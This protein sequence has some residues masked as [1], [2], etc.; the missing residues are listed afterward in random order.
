M[1][2]KEWF[3]RGRRLD[4]RIESLQQQRREEWERATS[5]TG[6]LDGDVVDGTK[7]PHKFDRFAVLDGM[8]GEEIDELLLIKCEIKAVIAQLDD[9]RYR[10]VLDKRY[11]SGKTWEQIAVEMNYTYRRV[12]QLHGEALAVSG[13]L[14]REVR[15]M[16]E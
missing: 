1:T 6:S 4:K 7:D 8:I 9:M 2:T 13:P 3:S 11:V 5:I 14:I 12:I 10:D 16:Q 15:P